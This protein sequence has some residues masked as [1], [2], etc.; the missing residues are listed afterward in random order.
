MGLAAL[1]LESNP[2]FP[3]Y[4]HRLPSNEVS[5]GLVLPTAATALLGKGGAYASLL[6]VFMAVTSAMSAE[7]VAVSSIVTYDIYQ[8]YINPQAKGR[9]LIQMSHI[10][11][12]VYAV[13][14]AGFST[15]LYY[16][17]FGC[18]KPPP[19]PFPSTTY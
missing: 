6:M 5:A 1:A 13:I 17:K 3:T 11:C 18:R 16:S 9:S 8:T 2:I 7:L 19:P 4:P 15:G 12:V 14:M 10:T